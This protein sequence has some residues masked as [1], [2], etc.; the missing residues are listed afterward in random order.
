[1]K[2]QTIEI[3]FD[4]KNRNTRFVPLDR[5]VR[6][7]FLLSRVNDGRSMNYKATIPE[8]IPGQVLGIDLDRGV[9]YLLEPIH[10]HLHI[11]TMLEKQG[12]RFEDARQEFPGIDVDAWLFWFKRMA[13]DGKVRIIEGK[14][15]E[16]VNYDPP[17]RLAPKPKRGPERLRE[18]FTKDPS[19]AAQYVEWDQKKR[20]AWESLV[21]V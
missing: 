15:P 13:D 20:A 11:K 1:M 16:T 9:G 14:L 12:Y 2:S 17:N 21:G 4:Y 10:D 7:R 3:Q 18:I 5:D 8:D 6:G 19:V